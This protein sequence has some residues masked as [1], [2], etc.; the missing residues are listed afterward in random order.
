MCSKSQMEY[1]IYYCSL[2]ADNLVMK[3]Q[4]MLYLT[5]A[6]SKL[7]LRCETAPDIST[8]NADFIAHCIHT[9][10]HG[11][12]TNQNQFMY[13]VPVG[14]GNPLIML[15]VLHIVYTPSYTAFTQIRIWIVRVIKR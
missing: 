2:I 7:K 3:N 5:T 9:K 4:L 11:V 13:Y 12:N 14:P 10:L 6:R 1:K 15:I 8:N